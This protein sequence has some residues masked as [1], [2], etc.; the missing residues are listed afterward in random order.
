M[1]ASPLDFSPS[2][3]AGSVKREIR[4]LND[5]WNKASIKMDLDFINA[6]YADDC[7]FHF[8]NGQSADK[9]WVMKLLESGD[10]HVE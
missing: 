2:R 3:S 8:P 6:F 10:V 9:R 1:S 5:A 4:R 7:I